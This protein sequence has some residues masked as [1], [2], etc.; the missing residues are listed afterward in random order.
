MPASS[1]SPL[2]VHFRGGFVADWKVV[3]RLLDIET[4]GCRFT[5]ENAGRF[6]VIPPERLTTEDI[7]FL[8]QRRDEARQVLVYCEEMAAAPC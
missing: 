6:R 3:Q 1:D 8:R 2:V 4:R 7:A 5:L